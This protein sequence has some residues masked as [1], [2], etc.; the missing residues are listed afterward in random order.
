[1]KIYKSRPI[2]FSTQKGKCEGTLQQKTKISPRVCN[3]YDVPKIISLAETASPPTELWIRSFWRHCTVVVLNYPWQREILLSVYC[4]LGKGG[5]QGVDMQVPSIT[6]YRRVKWFIKKKVLTVVERF[7]SKERRVSY[8]LLKFWVIT[9][10]G[11][12]TVS[13]W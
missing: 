7:S 8:S 9:K 2:R 10:I 3:I 6:I 11:A 4:G 5:W 13:N 12:G 1:M